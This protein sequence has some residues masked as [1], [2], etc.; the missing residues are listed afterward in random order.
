MTTRNDQADSAPA[1]AT[2]TPPRPAG[3]HHVPALVLLWILIIVAGYFIWP[4]K[5]YLYGDLPQGKP[6][7]STPP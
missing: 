1:V 3:G 4:S 5:S 2:E 6:A 7:V